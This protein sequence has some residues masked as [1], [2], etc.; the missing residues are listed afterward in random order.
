M[1]QHQR[2]FVSACFRASL[3]LLHLLLALPAPAWFFSALEHSQVRWE[4]LSLGHGCWTDVKGRGESR[5][6][7]PPGL[8]TWVIPILA[9][10]SMDS[11]HVLLWS[12]VINPKDY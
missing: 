4:L 3:Q 9:Q 6:F 12:G 7:V 10:G 5:I 11:I 8:L 2:P 1:T